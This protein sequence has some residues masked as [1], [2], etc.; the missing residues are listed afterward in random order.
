MPDLTIIVCLFKPGQP[1][2]AGGSA[3]WGLYDESWVD[4]LYRGFRRHSERSFSMIC[5]TDFENPK[6]EEPITPVPFNYKPHVGQW[7]SINEVF[8]PDW[9]IQR[10]LFCGLDTVI[11]GP[12]D[13]I[14]SFDGT[15]GMTRDAT[16]VGKVSNAM[17]LFD[18]AAMTD[19]WYLYI[20]DPFGWAARS[21]AKWSQGLGSEMV[22]WRENCP[23]SIEVLDDIYPRRFFDFSKSAG[24]IPLTAS[25]VYFRGTSKPDRISEDHWVKKEWKN[26]P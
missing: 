4:K 15:I 18:G 12:M 11:C 1:K 17:V 8:H 22:F 16:V 25:V 2:N 5:I 6:F 26:D 7:M 24:V 19:L 13:D 9:N 21:T 20:R 3:G 10:G 14:M 23:H